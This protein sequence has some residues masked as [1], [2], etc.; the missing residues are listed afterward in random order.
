M[1]CIGLP[2]VAVVPDPGLRMAYNSLISL[3][4]GLAGFFGQSPMDFSGGETERLLVPQHWPPP[5]IVTAV[6]GDDAMFDGRSDHYL[7]VG[8][9]ALHAIFGAVAALG[10]LER[11][12]ELSC[13]H[14][15]LT[16]VLRA[17]FLKA[18]L[19]VCDIDRSASITRPPAAGVRRHV[20]AGFPQAR[21]VRAV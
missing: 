17:R 13:N 6:A 9:S 8:L 1:P 11:M 18:A 10:E 12:L 16:R 15:R 4:P 19:K 21:P 3:P 20:D 7:S 14:G 5:W 2:K